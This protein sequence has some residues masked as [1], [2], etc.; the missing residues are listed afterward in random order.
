MRHA[1]SVRKDA[2]QL[3]G[4]PIAHWPGGAPVSLHSRTSCALRKLAVHQRVLGH[5]SARKA[6]ILRWGACGCAQSCRAVFEVPACGSQGDR[7]QSV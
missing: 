4:M 2:E 7:A 3:E 1:C 5:E 6:L